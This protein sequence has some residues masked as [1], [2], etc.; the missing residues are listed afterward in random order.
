[1]DV[2]QRVMKDKCTDFSHS[3]AL[4]S[5]MDTDRP[6]LCDH[7]VL[8]VHIDTVSD[9]QDQNALIHN[10]QTESGLTVQHWCPLRFHS[11]LR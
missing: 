8:R 2:L 4:S 9:S 3:E 1:M 6:R 5:L 11:S 7:M 10:L